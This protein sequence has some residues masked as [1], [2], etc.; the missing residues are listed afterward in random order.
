M[1]LIRFVVDLSMVSVYGSLPTA[2]LPAS[3]PGPAL[4]C[5]LSAL[6]AKEICKSWLRVPE[7]H[8]IQL[9]HSLNE[10]QLKDLISANHS[11]ESV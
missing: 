3:E 9:L 8:L 2:K 7:S 11:C 10:Q 6:M 5:A 4:L 1:V